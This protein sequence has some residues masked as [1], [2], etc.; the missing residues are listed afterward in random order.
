MSAQLVEESLQHFLNQFSHL[1]STTNSFQQPVV[2]ALSGGLDSVVLAHAFSQLC[3]ASM[4]LKAVYIHHGLQKEADNWQSFCENFCSA[5]NIDFESIRITVDNSQRQGLEAAAREARYQALFEKVAEGGV[6]LTAHHRQDQAE[7]LLLNLFRGAGLRGLAAMP[8]IKSVDFEGKSLFHARPFLPLSKQTL[9]EYAQTHSLNWVE[10][11]SNQSSEFKRNYL[12]NEM[13]PKISRAW[14]HAELKISQSSD[15]VREALTL[16]EELAQQDMQKCDVTRFSLDLS[17]VSQLSWPR[18][19][20]LLSW[21]AKQFLKEF[22]FTEDMFVWLEEALQNSNPQAHPVKKTRLGD[23]RVEGKCVYYLFDLKEEY[24]LDWPVDYESY[25]FNEK[26]L[27]M[28]EVAPVYFTSAKKI[29]LRPLSDDERQQ[30]P[31]L[32]K[33][34]KQN[35]VVFWNRSR[36]PV[37]EVDGKLAAILGFKTFSEFK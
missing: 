5:L 11:P 14:P 35:R 16:L 10:D 18:Q 29:V 28:H 27:L 31:E 12:R 22:R 36:W 23:L 19:K 20:N 3:P 7:T 6:L 34:F 24:C 21:W 26:S 32:K 25:H 30:F 15:H 17:Q 13:W 2:I 1:K 9:H 4:P 8:V 37:L 33:W